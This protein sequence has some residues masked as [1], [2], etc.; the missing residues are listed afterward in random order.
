MVV[1]GFRDRPWDLAAVGAYILLVFVI[2]LLVG[3]GTLLG[4]GLVMLAPGYAFVAALFP[5]DDQ[6]DWVAR[7]TLSFAISLALVPLALVVLNYTPFGFRLP[8]AVGITAII[9]AI[10]TVLAYTRRLRVAPSARLSYKIDLSLPWVHGEGTF[11]RVLTIGLVASILVAVGA[12]AYALNTPAP[13]DPFTSFY[14][15]GSGGNASGYPT[16]L[17]LSQPGTVFLGIVNHE[18]ASVNYTIRIDLVG[19]RIVY[20]ATSGFNQTVEVNRTTW[21]TF[22][23]ILADSQSWTQPYTFSI[24][25]VGLWKVQFLLFKDGDFSSVYRELHLFIRVG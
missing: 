18:S 13:R 23:I 8:Y 20:N 24:L 5:R 9:T 17:N 19:V 15:L 14:I 11:D 16:A 3:A 12:V 25:C 1:V 21:S 6:L 4:A 7:I 22:N 2:S 10:L